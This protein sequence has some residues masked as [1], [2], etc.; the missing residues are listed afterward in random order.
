MIFGVSIRL[1]EL[2]VRQPGFHGLGATLQGPGVLI[3]VVY[4]PAQQC[5]VALEVL[6]D[7]LFIQANAAAARG[8]LGGG[9]GEFKRL[10]DLEVWQAFN[11]K[12]A[13]REDVLFAFF[14]HGEITALKC[15]IR[16]GVNQVSQGD[17]RLHLALETY[18]HRL[19]HI[20]WHNA[21]GGCKS[22]QAGTGW[23]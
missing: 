9:I 21:G 13:A 3:A 10:L 12:N 4:H 20:E 22:H 18:Q 2:R 1:H 16:D 5:D 8:S 7:R 19:R 15:R 11:F 23:K 6:N 17:T 14:R